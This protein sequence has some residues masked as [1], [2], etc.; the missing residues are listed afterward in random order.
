MEMQT[1]LDYLRVVEHH[2]GPLRQIVRKVEKRV[3]LHFAVAVEQ[4]F[5]GV[6][7]CERIFRNA[8]IGQRIVVIADVDMLGWVFCHRNY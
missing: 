1:R 5:R 7:L 2:Q 6:A 3:F 4:Q 8:F